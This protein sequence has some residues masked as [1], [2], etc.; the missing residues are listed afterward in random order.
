[1]KLDK[2]NFTMRLRLRAGSRQKPK[3]LTDIT[4]QPISRF[5]DRVRSVSPK[6]MKTANNIDLEA[7]EKE[8]SLNRGK[9]P[10]LEEND[11]T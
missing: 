6:K 7:E 8:N 10:S 2:G 1:M 11:L 5:G 9:F 3:K 4:L